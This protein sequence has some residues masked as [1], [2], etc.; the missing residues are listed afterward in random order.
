MQ[1]EFMLIA[2]LVLLTFAYLI[3]TIVYPEKF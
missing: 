2:P 1:I 3:Y